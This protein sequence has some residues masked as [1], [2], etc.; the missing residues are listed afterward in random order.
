M[1]NFF[2]WNC[3]NINLLNIW[4]ILK[5]KGKWFHFDNAIT[6]LSFIR[7]AEVKINQLACL[8]NSWKLLN[9]LITI[10]SDTKT[11]TSNTFQ[12]KLVWN[13]NL[14]RWISF[15]LCIY[16]TFRYFNK[17]WVISK[18]SS[19]RKRAV[20]SVPGFSNIQIFNVQK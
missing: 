18:F 4:F 8:E 1:K 10:S 17:L 13:V 11:K 20:V 9:L 7:N 3:P 2:T 16:W 5:S 15:V 19:F 6:I 14:D 12:N